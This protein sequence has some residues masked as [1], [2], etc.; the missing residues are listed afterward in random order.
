V[1]QNPRIEDFVKSFNEGSKATIVQRGENRSSWFLEAA[2][3]AVGGQRGQIL[4]P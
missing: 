2:I 4:I 3:Y 1:L